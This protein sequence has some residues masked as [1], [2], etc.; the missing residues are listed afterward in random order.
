MV[1]LKK[2][3]G[4]FTGQA[5][6]LLARHFFTGETMPTQVC[7]VAQNKPIYHDMTQKT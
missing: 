2:K 3:L 1:Q 5:K 6:I 7:S 4:Q